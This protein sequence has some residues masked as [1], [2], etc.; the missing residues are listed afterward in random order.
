LPNGDIQ[1]GNGLIIRNDPADPNFQNNVLRDLTTMSNY[2]TGMNTLNSL[3]NS[4]QTVNIQHTNVAGGNSY[5][6]SNVA[7]ALPNGSRFGSTTG[8]GSGSGG[9][10]DY[11][12]DYE[13]P[14]DADPSINRPADVGLNHELT[15]AD[16]AAH[17]NYD[18]TTPDPATPNNPHMEE[19]NTIDRD[20][21]YRDERGIPRRTDHTT[22]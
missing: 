2:P 3:N 19:T 15:H 10:V 9:T 13:P 17:G 22:L 20:N 5:T 6:P 14:T 8:N 4:G 7:G 1:V 21:A 16:H 11:N 12:P 18:I